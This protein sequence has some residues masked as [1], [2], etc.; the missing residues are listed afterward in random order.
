MA[1]VIIPSSGVAYGPITVEAERSS[2]P[3]REELQSRS[4][5]ED[6]A[7]VPRPGKRP[8]VKVKLSSDY[9]RAKN[10]RG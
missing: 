6:Q 3:K 10:V 7:K 9:E 4:K 2:A 5:R 1:G 8:L